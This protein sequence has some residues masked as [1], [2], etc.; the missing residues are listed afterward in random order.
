MWQP[1]KQKVYTDV[2]AKKKKKKKNKKQKKKPL[3][4]KL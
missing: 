2:G 4:S 1:T 3:T